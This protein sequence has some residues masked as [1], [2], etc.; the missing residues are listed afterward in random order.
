MTEMKKSKIRVRF[1]SIVAIA[2]ILGLLVDA[3]LETEDL[4]FDE[5]SLDEIIVLLVFFIGVLRLKCENCNN[6]LFDWDMKNSYLGFFWKYHW[7]SSMLKFL[8]GKHCPICKVK[9]Y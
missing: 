4:F 3:Q 8:V 5:Y 1:W 9:R 7:V 6:T 2:F